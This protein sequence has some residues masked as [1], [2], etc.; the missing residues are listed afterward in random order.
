[1]TIAPESIS[2]L[3]FP[4][5]S[6]QDVLT[7]AHREIAKTMLQPSTAL[8]IPE[9]ETFEERMLREYTERTQEEFWALQ[10][11]YGAFRESMVAIDEY[12][13]W[14]TISYGS[15]PY[16]DVPGSPCYCSPSRGMYLD[17]SP[18]RGMYLAHERMVDEAMADLV[19][20]NEPLVP[21]G[22][23]LMGAVGLLFMVIGILITVL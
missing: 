18:S 14:P 13:H 7:E 22:V 15:D 11:T 16:A 5:P 23:K 9:P 20:W 12:M 8:A 10:Q 21:F 3:D 19:G 6:L 17:Y 4:A 1:M 2:E